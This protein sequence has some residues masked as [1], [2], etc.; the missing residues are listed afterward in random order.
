MYSHILGAALCVSQGRYITLFHIKSFHLY[1]IHQDDTSRALTWFRTKPHT[2]SSKYK[3]I[4]NLSHWQSL[5]GKRVKAGVGACLQ[6]SSG[7]TTR[8]F[9]IAIWWSQWPFI[10]PERLSLLVF[11]S[12]L[13]FLNVPGFLLWLSLYP[14]GWTSRPSWFVQMKSP[15]LSCLKKAYPKGNSDRTLN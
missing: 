9:G 1:K 13:L 14:A 2:C 7:I 3:Q 15:V 10:S 8:I 4:C 5:E 11:L 6:F 12:L